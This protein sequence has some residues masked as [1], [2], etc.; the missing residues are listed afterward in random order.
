MFLKNEPQSRIFDTTLPSNL[1]DFNNLSGAAQFSQAVAYFQSLIQAILK[2]TDDQNDLVGGIYDLLNA[3]YGNTSGDITLFS[4][5]ESEPQIV[6]LTNINSFGLRTYSGGIGTNSTETLSSGENLV[7]TNCHSPLVKVE[8]PLDRGTANGADIYELGA[9]KLRVAIE[10]PDVSGITYG[11]SFIAL[12]MEAP[13]GFSMGVATIRY[14][15][16]INNSDQSQ[17]TFYPEG[18]GS[19]ESGFDAFTP[20]EVYALLRAILANN[21][22]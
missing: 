10:P 22:P 19:G 18:Q 9:L 20:F 3:D 8:I 16:A 13:I 1:P 21:N 15:I 12:T 17:F 6:C 14:L 7:R 11:D 4:K 5:T 2:T